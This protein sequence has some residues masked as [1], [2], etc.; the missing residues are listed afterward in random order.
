[1]LVGSD[2]NGL[3]I[4]LLSELAEPSVI[5]LAIELNWFGYTVAQKLNAARHV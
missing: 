3:G 2:E 4:F 5:I 1:M